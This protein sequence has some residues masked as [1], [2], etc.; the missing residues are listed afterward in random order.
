MPTIIDMYAKTPPKTGAANVKGVDTTPI[1]M[2]NP[3]GEMKP[4]KDLIKDEK[5]LFKA[6][7]G[8]LKTKKYSSNPSLK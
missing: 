1:G 3:R 8:V 2:D 5:R 6:R 7:G 4:S